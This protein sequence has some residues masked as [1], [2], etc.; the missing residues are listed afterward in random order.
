MNR[1]LPLLTL[2]AAPA[3]AD[4]MADYLDRFVGHYSPQSQCIGQEF[5]V[6]MMEDRVNLGETGC[7]LDSVVGLPEGALQ[8]N[9]VRCNAEGEPS[10]DNQIVVH[11]TGESLNLRGGYDWRLER[12]TDIT[13]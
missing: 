13:N 3:A 7:A 4:P 8:L 2:L 1:L 5:I 11:F 10:P 9:L 6:S 12:C